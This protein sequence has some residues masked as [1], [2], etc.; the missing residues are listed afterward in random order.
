[1]PRA[2]A[3]RI[4]VPSGDII[5]WKWSR[6][7]LD[8]RHKQPKY[9]GTLDVELDGAAAGLSQA[10]VPP[11]P[12]FAPIRRKPMPR[13]AVVGAGP[14]GLFVTLSLLQCGVAPDM[15]ERGNE[16]G[17]RTKDVA[18]LMNTGTLNSESNICF[19][20]GGAGAFSDGKLMTRTKSD[21]INYILQRFV[22][23]G[24]EPEIIYDAHPHIGTDRLSPILKQMRNYMASQGVHHYFA[25]RVADLDISDGVCRALILDSGERVDYDAVFLC[26]GHSADAI[27][28]RLQ[29]RILLQPKPLAIGFRVEHPQALI[30]EIQYGKYAE[31][32]LLPPAEYAVRANPEGLPSA[33]SFCMCPGGRIVAS[34]TTDD[35]RVVNGMSGSKRNGKYANSAIVAQVF[36]EDYLPG[37]LG[38]LEWIRQIERNAGEGLP[39]A[40]AP[41]QMLMDFVRERTSSRTP[42]STYRPGVESRDLN[43]LLPPR[44]AEAL[45]VSFR[46]FDGQMRGFLSSE[47][48][49]VGVETRTSS[50][51]RIV[52]DESFQSVSARNLYP[53]GEG[54]GYAGGIT[55]CALDGINSVKAW[56]EMYD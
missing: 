54:A 34:Q 28:E 44:V 23:F 36:P 10:P 38:G 32:P 4:G 21:Y 53:V 13:V 5:S 45:R 52:R 47:A 15:Y 17:Q 29:S 9:Q 3:Q 7:S 16:V 22:D 19:G 43:Q 51:V 31:H 20:E 48:T 46:I 56:R 18:L 1:M 27:Y 55:S 8:V 33:F 12:E 41:A 42:R 2:I 14:A 49:I 25:T 26:V 37:P 30:N 40:I 24:A 35:T 6:R 39:P 50:P 11:V